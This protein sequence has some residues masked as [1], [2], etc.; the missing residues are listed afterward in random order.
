MTLKLAWAN[1]RRSYKDFAIYFLTL[2]VGVAVF[3][4]FNSIQAQQG[5]LSL[6]ET[7]SSSL[8]LFTM[9][10][11]MVSVLITAIMAFLVVYASR[12]LIKRRNKEFGLYLLLGMPRVILLRLTAVETLAVGVVSLAAG[13]A[14]G[15]GISQV[16]VGVT[17]LMFHANTTGQFT[18]LFAGDVALRTVLIFCAIFALSLLLNVGYLMRAKLVDLLNA[19]RKN[20]ALTLRSI[21]L[22]F[23]LFVV[24]CVLIGVAYWLLTENGFTGSDQSFTASTVLVCAGTVLFFYSLSGFLL[25]VVQTVKPLYYK[26]LNMFALR[27]VASRINST[28]VSMSII[29]MTLFFAITSVCSG[30]GIANALNNGYRDGYDATVR[31]TFYNTLSGEALGDADKAGSD[32]NAALAESADLVGG[33]SWNSMVKETAQVDFYSSDFMFSG[34]DKLATK[35]L[36]EYAVGTTAEYGEVPVLVVKLSQYNRALQMEGQPA[37]ELGKNEALIAYDMDM[38]NDYYSDV[39]A[40]GSITLY[41]RTMRLAAQPNSTSI[42][43]TTTSMNTGALVVDDSVV[44]SNAQVVSSLLDINYVDSGVETHWNETMDKIICSADPNVWTVNMLQTK[45]DV[46]DTGVGLT[47]VVGYLAI[48]IG[49]VLVVACAA[50]LA[51]QQLTAAS[52]NRRR[53]TLLAKLGATRGMLDGA[54]FKQVAIAFLFPLVLAV[55]HSVCA[56][57]AVTNVVRVFGNVEIGQVALV[58]SGAFVLVYG[59]YFLLTFFQA[60]GIIHSDS[61]L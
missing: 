32:M 51:I 35:P 40:G 16:L 6:N 61:E 25:R 18:F 46:H 31:S 23:A 24:S 9:V 17:A 39:C 54:L 8:E 47:T 29:C 43:T 33:T 27:E 60:R 19:E 22:S 44:P 49:L 20:E 14:V 37:V 53:Y 38:L 45:Q 5:V 41:G 13:L 26:G 55:C 2:L 1:V 7:Q 28:F 48:Y 10:S 15:V 58:A 3:Y 21:P 59:L 36:S 4:A 11:N 52:D 57:A 34:F 56:T 50:I 12:F 30:M 42:E